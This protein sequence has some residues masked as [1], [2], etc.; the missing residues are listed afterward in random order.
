[1]KIALRDNRL[2]RLA[3]FASF[4]SAEEAHHHRSQR[5]QVGPAPRHSLLEQRRRSCSAIRKEGLFALRLKLPAGYVV[6]PHTHPA[7][8]WSQ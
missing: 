3:G 8:R 2:D 4:A 1:M 5:Y 7:M 6:L